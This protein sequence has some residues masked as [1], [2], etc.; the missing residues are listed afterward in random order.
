MNIFSGVIFLMEEEENDINLVFRN[1]ELKKIDI[2]SGIAN[3]EEELL[4]EI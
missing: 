3:F 4:N 1:L 2:L